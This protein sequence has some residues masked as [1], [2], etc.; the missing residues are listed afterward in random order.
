MK[1]GFTLVELIIVMV[2]LGILAAVA[3]PKFMCG[4]IAAA[5]VNSTKYNLGVLRETLRLKYSNNLLQGLS[6]WPAIDATDFHD[7]QI[8]L[9]ML[10]N[11][12]SINLVDSAETFQPGTWGL[13]PNGPT[14]NAYGWWYDSVHGKMGAYSDSGGYTPTP[15]W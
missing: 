11:Q 6:G 15:E 7:G 5:K 4:H 12:R 13:P 3:M 14:S 2:I 8:P 1:K 9:N 10:N